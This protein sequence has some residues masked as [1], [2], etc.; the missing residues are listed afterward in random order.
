MWG[1]FGHATLKM[2]RQRHPAQAVEAEEQREEE[3]DQEREGLREGAAGGGGAAALLEPRNLREGAV[4]GGP[5]S[6][7]HPIPQPLSRIV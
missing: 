6:T 4:G 5:L 3:R 1:K 7:L 2:L